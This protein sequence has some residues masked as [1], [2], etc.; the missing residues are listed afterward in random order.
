MR[1]SIG[2]KLAVLVVSASAV[3]TMAPAAD[4]SPRDSL[5]TAGNPALDAADFH[6]FH[7][8][9]PG[10]A[11]FTT[12]IA[13]YYPLRNA[14]GGPLYGQLENGATYEIS[15]DNNGNGK[16]DITF[17]VKPKVELA[18]GGDGQ[19]LNVGGKDVAVPFAV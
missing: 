8:S 13:T 18:A 14:T 1:R 12:M 2:R 17:Q 4:A 10:R 6:M 9:E 16:E 5:C 3:L 19:T 11:G 7:S 15:I